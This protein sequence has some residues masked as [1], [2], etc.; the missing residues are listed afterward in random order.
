MSDIDGM[1]VTEFWLSD[2]LNQQEFLSAFNTRFPGG[3]AELMPVIRY[4]NPGYKLFYLDVPLAMQ[5]DVKPFLDEYAQQHE[6]INHRGPSGGYP[7]N[8]GA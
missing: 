8:P 3:W 1:F 2:E 4:A 5:D 7:F 6:A